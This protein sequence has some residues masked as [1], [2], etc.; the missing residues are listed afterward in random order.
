ME[1]DFSKTDAVIFNMDGTIYD[2]KDLP[3]RMI[4]SD[5]LHAHW[6][7]N[8]KKVRTQ[9][10]N[11]DFGDSNNFYSTYFNEMAKICHTTKEKY[12]IWYFTKFLPNMCN[13]INDYCDSREG[14]NDI[15]MQLRR[16]EIPFLIYSDYAFA[17]ERAHVLGLKELSEDS[18]ICADEIGCQKPADRGYKK[19]EKMVLY[20]RPDKHNIFVIS[21]DDKD[22]EGAT[23]VGFSFIKIVDDAKME[24]E[25]TWNQ[26]LQ[27]FINALRQQA[28]KKTH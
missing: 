15:F 27:K 18:F 22:G 3:L 19:I 25:I 8:D 9:L 4:L 21:N 1:I 20:K 24:N 2:D 7:K 5:P 14:L 13:I 11:I 10:R 17:K 26:F 28:V 23:K 16:C 12:R 6:I